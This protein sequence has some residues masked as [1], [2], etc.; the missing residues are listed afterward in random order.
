[1]HEINSLLVEEG[2]QGRN[3][4]DEGTKVPTVRDTPQ[5]SVHHLR[6]ARIFSFKTLRT[7]GGR[8]SLGR[9]H[10]PLPRTTR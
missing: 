5:D 9:P 7:D 8:R 10:A 1:M 6:L 4:Q 2:K 3:M